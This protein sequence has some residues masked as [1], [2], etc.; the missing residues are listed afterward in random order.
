MEPNPFLAELQ[1]YYVLWQEYNT[2]YAAWAKAHGL[3]VN[4]LLVLSALGEGAEDCTQRKISQR[5]LLPKQTV[6]MV[7]KDLEEKGYVSLHPLGEDKRNKAIR[8]TS[9]GWAYAQPIL[10]ALREVELAVAQEM[11]LSQMQT[12]ND[13]T[14]RFVALFREK[15][16][17]T[18]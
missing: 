3:S 11:G 7:L 6:H 1:R 5:W 18:L 10:S 13:T 12:L 4:S 17:V 2:V 14:A 15:G 9:A 16:G 8:F